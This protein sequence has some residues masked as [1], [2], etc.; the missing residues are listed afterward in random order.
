MANLWERFENIASVDEV[1]DARVQFTPVQAGDYDAMLESIEPSESKNGLPMIKGKFRLVANNRIVFYNQTLQNLNYPD[2]T[3]KNIAE[4]VNFIS[5]LL[6]QDIEFQ[7][8]GHLAS[9]IYEIPSGKICR[10]N[11]SYGKGDDEMKFPK[12]KIVDAGFD[13]EEAF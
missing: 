4:A 11:V 6:G 3:A 2:M 1:A 5:G 10:I 12:L 9:L 13:G 7:G 8:L